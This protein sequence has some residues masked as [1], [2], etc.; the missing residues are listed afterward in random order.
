MV[1]KN[2]KKKETTLP[3]PDPVSLTAQSE[4]SV[5]EGEEERI[6][7]SSLAKKSSPGEEHPDRTQRDWDHPII[8][9]VERIEGHLINLEHTLRELLA[10]MT[11]VRELLS[12]GQGPGATVKKRG[13]R[14]GI[15][16]DI[17][18]LYYAAKDLGGKIDYKRL[19]E[20]I[21]AGRTLAKANA[22]VV[23]NPNVHDQENF[24]RALENYGFQLRTKVIKVFYDGNQKGNWDL[25]MAVDMIEDADYLD[26]IALIS[27]DGDF[28]PVVRMLKRK[29]VRVEV[30]SFLHT[31]SHELREAADHFF[32]LSEAFLL[33]EEHTK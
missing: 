15:Y 3:S 20:W 4:D 22:Y 24:L 21:V 23:I 14:L 32:P 10:E 31:L 11:T 8:E 33:K 12:A 27:G 6:R 17:Q 9:R 28:A 18:N 25:G 7:R 26:I 13:N 19:K 1:K 30:Y 2:G 16:V 5:R 29:G